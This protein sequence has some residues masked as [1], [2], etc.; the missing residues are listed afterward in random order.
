MT[1]RLAQHLD[2]LS[3]SAD[4]LRARSFSG[5]RSFQNTLLA[6]VS[7]TQLIRDAE[8]HES[9]LFTTRAERRERESVP[10]SGAA[11]VLKQRDA[12]L[13]VLLE[14]LERVMRLYPSAVSSSS[15][16]ATNLTSTTDG[17]RG[18]AEGM[19][20]RVEMMRHKGR[21]LERNIADLEGQ[22]DAQRR[23]LD[24]MSSG[25]AAGIYT[26]GVDD[27][28]D[29]DDNQRREQVEGGGGGEEGQER[30]EEVVVTE[31]MIRAEEEEIT[32]LERLIESKSRR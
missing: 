17:S 24:E 7:I 23:R 30:I 15:S 19:R 2:S 27:D 6:R 20:E 18:D 4:S 9:A 14:T 11:G 22:V 8:P 21:V 13:P 26:Q 10:D 28:D 1:T 16:T 32:R 31:E 29:D 12:S 3:T 25:R 5:T